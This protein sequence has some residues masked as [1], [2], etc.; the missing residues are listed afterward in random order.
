MT[1]KILKK[2]FNSYTSTPSN[3]I[4]DF[5]SKKTRLEKAEN[6]IR[7]IVKDISDKKSMNFNPRNAIEKIAN[8]IRT[9]Y[10]K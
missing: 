5:T 6:L 7:G 4:F 2:F 8:R 3:V 9:Y 10:K 1:K